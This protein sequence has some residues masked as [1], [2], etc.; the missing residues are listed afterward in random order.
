MVSRVKLSLFHGNV[1][2]LSNKMLRIQG[3]DFKWEQ[4]GFPGVIYLPSLCKKMSDSF[5]LPE[6]INFVLVDRKNNNFE[7]NKHTFIALKSHCVS[8]FVLIHN[9]HIISDRHLERQ[10][11]TWCF[12]INYT[13]SEIARARR[14]SIYHFR[15]LA[16]G[17]GSKT[18]FFSPFFN[19]LFSFM[20]FTTTTEILQTFEKPLKVE[21]FG[22]LQTVNL[23]FVFKPNRCVEKGGTGIYTCIVTWPWVERQRHTSVKSLQIVTCTYEE[24]KAC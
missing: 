16:T 2:R 10:I 1:C 19:F 21:N 4:T 11:Y 8:Y 14:W 15:R 17:T 7:V 13:F 12:K 23:V 9:T 20:I 22:S 18:F 3:S 5:A 6:L 24:L